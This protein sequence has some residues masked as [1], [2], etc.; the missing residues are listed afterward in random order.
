MSS[1]TL[2]GKTEKWPGRYPKKEAVADI[3]VDDPRALNLIHYNT[4]DRETLERQLVEI[5]KL[6]GPDKFDGFQLNIAWPD[7]RDI[8]NFQHQ[9]YGLYPDKF[10]VLQMGSKT[11]Q[12]MSPKTFRTALY[13]SYDHRSC[14]SWI[15]DAILIDPS[16]GEGKP[17]DTARE[18]EYLR[19][20]RA[21]SGPI[22]IGIAGGLGPDT[23]HLAEPLIHEFS[24]LSIDAEGRLRTPQPKDALDLDAMQ[25]YLAGAYAMFGEK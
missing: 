19:E 23:L 6:V 11:M 18:A 1:K 12:A 22:S 9:R 14:C 24:D 21:F 8:R 7:P 20:I 16:G 4:D 10:V 13:C 2:A 3:F 15:L 25:K 5:A 17:L